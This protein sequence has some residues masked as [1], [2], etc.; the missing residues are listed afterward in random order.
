MER[1]AY[2][3]D[4]SDAEWSLLEGLIPDWKP[5]G[6]PEKYSKREIVNGIRYVMRTGCAWRHLPHDLPAW[7][8]VYYYFR[9]WKKEGVWKQIHDKL[10]GDVREQAG[11]TRQPSAA[12][13]DSQSV[14][15]TEKGGRVDTTPAKRSAAASATCS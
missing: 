15:T 10:R 8:S 4:L 1:A 2:P 9:L 12:I 13:I 11:R 3:T 7:T 14:K 6:R 5:G